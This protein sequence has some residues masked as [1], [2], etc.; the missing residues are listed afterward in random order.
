MNTFLKVSF[1]SQISTCSLS[2][3]KFRIFSSNF[4]EKNVEPPPKIQDS[5]PDEILQVIKNKKYCMKF[6]NQSKFK[7]HYD[8]S[9]ELEQELHPYKNFFHY[10]LSSIFLPKNPK[11]RTTHYLS[12][13]KWHVIHWM[14]ISTSGVLASACLLYSLG[15]GST[16]LVGSTAGILNWIMRE[17]LGHLGTL[18]ISRFLPDQF[19]RDTK[20]WYMTSALT[21]NFAI[22]LEVITALNPKWFI[23]LAAT[24]TSL[25]GIAWLAS[26]STKTSFLVTFAREANLGDVLAKGTSQVVASSLIGTAT[27]TLIYFFVGNQP[28]ILFTIFSLLSL[29]S[30]YA[31]YNSVR[32]VVSGQLNPQHFE[33]LFQMVYSTSGQSVETF[34]FEKERLHPSQMTPEIISKEECLFWTI[35]K[36]IPL[37]NFMF[38][39]TVKQLPLINVGASLVNLCEGGSLETLNFLIEVYR[40]ENYLLNFSVIQQGSKLS[41][42]RKGVVNLVIHEDSTVDDVFCAYLNACFLA[43][44]LKHI[45]THNLSLSKDQIHHILKLCYHQT[46]QEL[47][48]FRRRLRFAGWDLVTLFLEGTPQRAVYPKSPSTPPPPPPPPTTTTTTYT[49]AGNDHNNQ[50]KTHIPPISND[51]DFKEKLRERSELREKSVGDVIRSSRKE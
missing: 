4:S 45:Q 41:K 18:L 22:G 34:V 14:S 27:G 31:A 7:L 6:E 43:L 8:K 39:N 49:S 42:N 35:N 37:P 17:G 19:D 5:N 25:K 20:F 28:T 2:L 1:L 33:Q 48:S 32:S 38:P 12:F 15:L 47:F 26:G 30:L 46:K 51:K 3:R 16:L 23:L 11:A 36:S 24:A 44:Y 13:I 50:T 9:E 10:H 29:N 21:V 40:E